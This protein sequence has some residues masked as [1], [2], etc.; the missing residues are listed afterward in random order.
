LGGIAKGYAIDQAL[1]AMKNNGIGI[2]LV[3]GG[4]DVAVGKAP[5]GRD[6]WRVQVFDGRRGTPRILFLVEQ[7]V[8]TSGD[9]FQFVEVDGKRY[10]HLVDSRTGIGLTSFVSSTVIAN[11]ATTADGWASAIA[12]VGAKEGL[13]LVAQISNCEATIRIREGDSVKEHRTKGF[14]QMSEP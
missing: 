5:P 4:G 7:A 13:K 10:S 11:D 3:N 14:P 2:S 9:L 6:H 12:L 1:A 8:A